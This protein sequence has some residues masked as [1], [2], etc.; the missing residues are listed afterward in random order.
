VSERAVR[1]R[2][3]SRAGLGVE[4]TTALTSAG[5]R[6]DGGGH[7][8]T[9]RVHREELQPAGVCR[10]LGKQ[11]SEPGSTGAITH[12]PVA[13]QVLPPTHP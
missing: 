2:L 8:R 7:G 11:T 12:L 6:S 3:P 9:G 1:G 4:L 10:M 13:N 5:R